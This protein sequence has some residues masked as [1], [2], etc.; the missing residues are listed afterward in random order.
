MR[1]AG[2]RG[3]IAETPGSGGSAT[4][5]RARHG[6][7]HSG[8]TREAPAAG[9]ADAPQS[10]VRCGCNKTA[11]AAGLGYPRSCTQSAAASLRCFILQTRARPACTR[12]PAGSAAT[13][14]QLSPTTSVVV[15][16]QQGSQAHKLPAPRL[17]M[18]LPLATGGAPHADHARHLA[19]AHSLDRLAAHQQKRVHIHR[20]LRAKGWEGGS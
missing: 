4:Q 2:L 1:P 7:Q 11:T 5:R 6:R 9:I 13:H 10:D 12:L 16:A 8:S 19:P 20:Q 18:L 17:T 3:G 14:P 15:A